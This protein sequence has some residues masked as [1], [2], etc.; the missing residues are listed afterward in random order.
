MPDPTPREL[1]EAEGVALLNATFDSALI[2]QCS[3][4]GEKPLSAYSWNILKRLGMDSLPDGVCVVMPIDNK[5]EFWLTVKDG[6]RLV[7][8]GLHEAIMGVGYNGDDV[9]P[10]VL[11]HP[12]CIELLAN[13]IMTSDSKDPLVDAVEFYEAS[14]FPVNLGKCTPYTFK[15][16]MDMG[17]TVG[18]ES[19][20]DL[21]APAPDDV[22]V[23]MLPVVVEIEELANKKMGIKIET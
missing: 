13:M 2:G 23:E 10:A 4:V 19:V 11:H 3:R 1:L 16:I 18:D 7:W 5:E 12:R 14:L 15:P 6:R 17:L 21:F 20:A 22:K 9:A 8:D